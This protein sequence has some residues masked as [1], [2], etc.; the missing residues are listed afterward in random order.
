MGGPPPD[1]ETSCCDYAV[2]PTT[3]REMAAVSSVCL[4][5]MVG[6]LTPAVTHQNFFNNFWLAHM[7]QENTIFK[8][9]ISL[10][11][12]LLTK[13]KALIEVYV[14]DHSWLS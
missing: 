4:E 2:K 11:R 10:A 9:S 5:F 14:S 7:L 6:L 13:I 3:V 1:N 8:V 12:M